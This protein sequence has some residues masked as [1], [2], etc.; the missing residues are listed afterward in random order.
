MSYCLAN[1]RNVGM[2]TKP[3][4]KNSKMDGSWVFKTIFLKRD[5]QQN[6]IQVQVHYKFDPTQVKIYRPN[7]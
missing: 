3:R 1:A 5:G 7:S 4:P 6:F 2:V